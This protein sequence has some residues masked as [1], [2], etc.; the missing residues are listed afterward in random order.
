MLILFTQQ[1]KT[2]D[3]DEVVLIKVLTQQGSWMQQN[4]FTHIAKSISLTLESL[5]YQI[6]LQS[7]K[8]PKIK[9][10]C[11]LRMKYRC[12]RIIVIIG[13]SIIAISATILKCSMK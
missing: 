4:Q 10:V 13:S 7:Q 11:A 2:D 6:Y 12:N 1:L 8:R 5:Y 3:I 9:E